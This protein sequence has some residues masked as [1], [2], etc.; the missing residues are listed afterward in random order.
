M[1]E[2]P[3]K[4]AERLTSLDA[5]RGFIMLFMATW[6]FHIG[7][8]GGTAAQFPDDPVWQFFGTQF[9]HSAWVG[10]TAYDLIQPSFMFMVG[11]ALPYSHASRRSRG[12]SRLK[13]T[14]HVLYR[15]VVLILLGIFLSS[16]S[17]T[18]SNFTFVNVL[19]QIGLG[20]AFVY[21]LV[22]RGMVLQ[23]LVALAILGGYWYL[24]VDPPIAVSSII[25]P[26]ISAADLKDGYVPFTGFFAHWNKHTN[27]AAAADQHLLK[28]FAPFTDS[29]PYNHGGYQTLNFV[30]S[31]ATM[32]FGLMAGELLRSSMAGAKKF[33]ILLV[34]AVAF[35]VVGYL[36][37]IWLCPSVKRIWTPSWTIF[38]TGWTL[39]LLAAFYGIIDLKGWKGWSFP[40]VVVGMNSIAMYCMAQLIHGWLGQTVQRHLETGRELLLKFT[41]HA[42]PSEAWQQHLTQSLYV[43][44]YARIARDASAVI[45]LWFIC[46]WMCRRKLFLRI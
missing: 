23:L 32:I 46:L 6:G 37:G 4:P 43:D 30:P 7:L 22:G 11:V 12:D 39:G 44:P 14:G 24:F 35:L 19:T 21:L 10:C 5:Y 13:I 29:Y 16:N 42:M 27:F 15:A 41:E 36:L 2:T 20:Y 45:M 9:G 1:G 8:P 38:S 33:R 26:D 31:M 28:L 3:L 40:L 25:P 34:A 18:R 17:G